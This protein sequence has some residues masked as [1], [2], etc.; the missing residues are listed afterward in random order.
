MGTYQVVLL[1]HFTLERMIKVLH[2]LTTFFKAKA[3]YHDER[4]LL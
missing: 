2:I 1:Q 3:I 4:H